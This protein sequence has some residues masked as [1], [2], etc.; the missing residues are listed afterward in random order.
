[1]AI[2]EIYKYPSPKLREIA[3][4]VKR[5]DDTIR[6]LVDD[7]AE[8]MYTA[9]GVGLAATQVGVRQRVFIIDIA[10][11]DEPSNLMVFINPEILA[12]EGSLRWKEGCLSFPEITE[13]IKRAERVKVRALGVDGNPFELTAEGLLA[14]AIQHENDHLDGALMIDKLSALKRRLIGRKLAENR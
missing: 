14:V 3:E 9:S 2:L 5:V 1:M 11:E 12:T 8:T 10:A 13:E 4:P 6:K 7:M